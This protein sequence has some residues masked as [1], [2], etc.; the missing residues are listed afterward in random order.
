MANN[1]N[2]LI[3]F[4]SNYSDID[5]L[6]NTKE[7]PDNVNYLTD[8]DLS[9]ESNEVVSNGVRYGSDAKSNIINS[10][11]RQVTL[12]T[13]GVAELMAKHGTVTTVINS[14]TSDAAILKS[15]EDSI[16][17]L[18]TTV[19]NARILASTK[20]TSVPTTALTSSGDKLITERTVFNAIKNSLD[21]DVDVEGYALDARQGKA[22]SLKI[23]ADISTETNARKNAISKVYKDTQENLKI[24]YLNATTEE[25][26]PTDGV[27]ESGFLYIWKGIQGDY[28]TFLGKNSGI[29]SRVFAIIEE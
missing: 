27:D 3:K 20:D 2:K 15:L 17:K 29:A 6:D 7:A 13:Y 24:K 23:T 18:A 10:I 19:S 1:N 22:L 14:L 8:A 16:E 28:T 5:G 12:I 11:L 21:T 26:E 4:F 25:Y 9:K